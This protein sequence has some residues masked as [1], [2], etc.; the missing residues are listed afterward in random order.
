VKI[1]PK[2]FLLFAGCDFRFSSS[3]DRYA[4][5]SCFDFDEIE[6]CR[7]KEATGQQKEG[8]LFDSFE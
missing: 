5:T 1:V 7:R 2:M 8:S 3:D 6:K 4:F